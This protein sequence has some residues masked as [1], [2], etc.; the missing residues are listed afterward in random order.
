MN[1][2]THTKFVDESNKNSFKTFLIMAG[3]SGFII[4]VGFLIAT[5]TGN[6]SYI[7]YALIFAVGQNL[8]S[9]FIGPKI[10]LSTSGAVKADPEKYSDLHS[11]VESIS[12]EA[13]IKKPDVYIIN[14]PA[15]NAFATGRGRSSS[16]VAVTTGL[17]A[18]LDRG[19]LEGVIAHEV[20]HI[21]NRDILVMTAVVT[22]SA[23]LSTLANMAM[24]ARMAGNRGGEN[25]GN[26]NIVFMIVGVAGSIVLPFAMMLIQMS[27]S[28]KREFMADAG[29]AILSKHPEALASALQKIGG[30]RQ[31]LQL[32]SP[33]TAHMYISCPFGGKEGQTFWQKLFLTH[34][35]T[36]ERVQALI[37]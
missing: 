12:V 24:Y 3:L 34:P 21:K 25:S 35:L 13:N 18:M 31:P 11:I 29:G 28:R 30:F 22:M 2:T 20:T 23:V 6:S 8:V 4:A 19:E 26:S 9:Y 15:P 37:G 27:I 17:M 5:T 10:A 14:D 1:N 32:A 33:A 36:E 16:S 7:T